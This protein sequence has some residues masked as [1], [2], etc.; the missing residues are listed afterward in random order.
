MTEKSPP[1]LIKFDLAKQSFSLVEQAEPNDFV[2]TLKDFNLL[3]HALQQAEKA[4]RLPDL[5][6]ETRGSQQE[7]YVDRDPTKPTA[8]SEYLPYRFFRTVVEKPVYK[9][10]PSKPYRWRGLLEP[11]KVAILC[12]IDQNNKLKLLPEALL[13]VLERL[14]EPQYVTALKNAQK[15]AAAAKKRYKAK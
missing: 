9:N 7:L 3:F 11:V 5:F 10:S 14:R 15:L 4:G 2:L 12:L 6:L 1:L 8:C 13:K